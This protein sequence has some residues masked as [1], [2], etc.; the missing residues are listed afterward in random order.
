MHHTIIKSCTISLLSDL[1]HNYCHYT[2]HCNQAMF[3]VSTVK[4]LK[5]YLILCTHGQYKIISLWQHLLII[6]GVT[7]SRCQHIVSLS[8]YYSAHCRISLRIPWMF[9]EDVFSLGGGLP[10]TG[11]KH[12]CLLVD[13]CVAVSLVTTGH[14][15]HKWQ[16]EVLVYFITVSVFMHVY[17]YFKLAP[18]EGQ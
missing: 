3:I 11:S 1:E 6:V 2:L 14:I 9:L 5:I 16:T 7:I 8:T 10:K 13:V 17:A 12:N 4:L 15:L 18:A